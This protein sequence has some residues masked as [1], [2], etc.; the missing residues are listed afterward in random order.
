MGGNATQRPASSS[1]EQDR[2]WA[3]TLSGQP[4]NQ[5]TNNHGLHRFRSYLHLRRFR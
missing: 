2:A 3:L 1:P 4:T 5:L